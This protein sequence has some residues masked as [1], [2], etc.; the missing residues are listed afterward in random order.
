MRGRT[1]LVSMIA[2]AALGLPAGADQP[3]E[4]DRGE[5]LAWHLEAYIPCQDGVGIADMKAMVKEFGATREELLFA[6]DMLELDENACRDLKKTSGKLLV[7]AMNEPEK[8][9]TAFEFRLAQDP[10]VNAS[11][12]PVAKPATAAE[13]LAPKSQLPP[14]K[15]SSLK[16][17]SSY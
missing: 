8:F 4:K 17:R 6:L 14:P 3:E 10:V 13:I 7:L 9:D 2:I 12:E 5:R 15:A 11:L 1:K 16:T